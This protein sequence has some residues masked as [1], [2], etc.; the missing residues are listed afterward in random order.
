MD[1]LLQKEII[2]E[3]KYELL[4]VINQLK[5]DEYTKR[6]YNERFITYSFSAG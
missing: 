5:D 4:K 2:V 1:R 3:L 6:A